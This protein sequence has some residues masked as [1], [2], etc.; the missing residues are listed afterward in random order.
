[1]QGHKFA[2]C[3]NCIDGRTQETAIKFIRERF[4]ADYIDMITEPGPDSILSLNEDKTLINSIKRRVRISVEKHGSFRI[5]IVGHYDCAG[6]PGDKRQH[7]EQ[8]KSSVKNIL[9]WG[10]DIPVSGIWINEEFK[11]EEIITQE[12]ENGFLKKNGDCE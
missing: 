9:G 5:L 8:I 4:G 12:R 10:L 7:L 6:N 2:T 1:M 11:A 3:I